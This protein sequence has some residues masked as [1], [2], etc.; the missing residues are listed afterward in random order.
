MFENDPRDLA[1]TLTEMEKLS[2]E[3]TNFN[4]VEAK[5]KFKEFLQRDRR[6][7]GF[8]Q[9]Q[10]VARVQECRSCGAVL[11]LDDPRLRGREARP[12]ERSRW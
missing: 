2:R 10:L 8:D 9:D 1:R 4:S 7:D 12:L 5:E 6:F 3:R 11:D